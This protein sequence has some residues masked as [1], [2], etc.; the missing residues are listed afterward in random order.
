MTD[1]RVEA[2]IDWM[3]RARVLG[4][5]AGL[6]NMRA[7]CEA[8]GHPERA[9]R[10]VHVAGTNGKGSVCAF[11]ERALSENGYRTGLY[12]S[13]YL[14]RYNERIR[15]LGEDISDDALLRAGVRVRKAADELKDIK[16]TTFELGTALAFCAFEEATV[17]IAVIETGIGGRFDPTNVISPMVSVI[18]T[19][20]FDHM[21]MLGDTLGAIASEKAGILKRATPAAFYPQAGEARRVLDEAALALDIPVARSEDYPLRGLEQDARGCVFRIELPRLGELAIRGNLPGTHQAENARLALAALDQLAGCGLELDAT[22]VERGIANAR[23]P[24]RLEWARENLLLDGAHNLEGAKALAEYIGTFLPGREIV[25]V[26]GMM[27]DKQP[28]AYADIIAPL[29]S[30]AVTTRVDWP[31]ALD[32]KTLADLYRARGVR[33]DGC[34]SAAEALR[35][36]REIAGSDAL[37]LVAGSLYLIGEMRAILWQECGKQR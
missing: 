28:G 22:A 25:L 5:K 34:P 23:W 14:T 9:F 19:I 3:Y 24:G 7:L 35:R 26:S 30:R 37:I 4:E 21:E 31:R 29:V 32:E 16:P 17:D 33:A 36:A 1:E 13:P 20:G 8:L 2:L 15:I 27:R 12:T 11:I 18:A 10:A 6:N